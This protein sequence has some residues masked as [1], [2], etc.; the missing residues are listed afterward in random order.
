MD[1]QNGLF[2]S[3]LKF[4]VACCVCSSPF[5][6]VADGAKILGMF[7]F[8]AYS[9]YA[10][11][12]P[13]LLELARRGH[14]VT[15]YS[16]FPQ[17]TKVPNL[18]DVTL[19]RAVDLHVNSI[20]FNLFETNSVNLLYDIYFLYAEL[21]N[22][23]KVLETK[24]VDQLISSNEKFDLVVTEYFNSE[25]L[26]GFAHRFN[27]PYIGMVSCTM[28]PWTSF[29]F[30]S[31]SNPSYVPI[32]FVPYTAHMSFTQRLIN[33]YKQIIAVLSYRYYF[34]PKTNAMIKKLF[35]ETTPSADD[36]VKNASLLFVNTHFSFHE[37]KPLSKKVVEIGGIHIKPP[38]KLPQDIQ[39][40]IDSS[41]H[42]VIYFCL[43]SMLRGSSL[44]NETWKAFR[45]VFA[46]L[47]Q[48]VLWKWEEDTMTDKPDNVKLLKW[49]PQQDILAHENVKLFIY[50]GGLL[51][52]LEAVR[53]GVPV[54]GIP[55][56]GDQARNIA[57]IEA[58]GA[59]VKIDIHDLTYEN[60]FSAVN[61]VLS[62]PS[63]SKNAKRLGK[64]FADRPL[65]AVDT[66]VYWTEYVLRHSGA[67]HLQSAAA[68]LSW[69]QYLLLDV[70]V[71]TL[72]SIVI[73]TTLSVF[74]LKLLFTKLRLLFS[75]QKQD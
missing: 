27:A 29:N 36:L 64:R 17:K 3:L 21:S 46:K 30:A 56:Y 19:E 38:K 33:T 15:V 75:K 20:P 66:A 65:S 9:H 12:E 55:V 13:L 63:Y 25:V 37:S 51:G 67:P 59:G 28:L 62:D 22:L 43:G 48:G 4:L 16:H 52:I 35:G 2:L 6:T 68:D 8:G 72:L 23:E 60:I 45:D 39:E 73:I 44:K 14:Q 18:T 47:T 69:Y 5:G 24:T 10:G 26:F 58:A 50:H 70:V 49:A 7:P 40:F 54:V 57:A 61:R 34:V 42:G 41:K 31:P 53:G 32:V 11:F 71:V 1:N 74:I